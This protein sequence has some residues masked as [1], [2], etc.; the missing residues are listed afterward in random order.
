MPGSGKTFLAKKIRSENKD[1]YTLIDDPRQISDVRKHFGK[2]LLICDPHLC[3]E[4]NRKACIEIFEKEGYKIKQVFFEEDRKKCKDNIDRRND[5]RIIN[6]K[7]FKYDI[8]KNVP[9]LKI[10]QP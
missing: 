3:V 8:P 6:L 10:W 7:N 1:K 4:S 5:K 2:N 9:L